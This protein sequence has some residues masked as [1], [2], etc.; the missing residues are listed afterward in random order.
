MILPGD[1]LEVLCRSAKDQV[2]L[3]APFTK[4]SALE[5][6][7]NNIANDVVIQCVTRWRP[8]E[9]VAG[10]SDLE[11]WPLLKERSDTFLWLRSDLHAKY[12]R[13][14]NQC[15]VGSA[16]ITATALGWS[17]QSNL[18]LLVPMPANDRQLAT[19]ETE[20]FI[21]CIKVDDSLFDQVSQ[22]V[23]LLTEQK[24]YVTPEQ[25]LIPDLILD[26]IGALPQVSVD[27][28]LPMLRHPEKLYIAYSGQEESL[29]TTAKI[30]A[31]SDL[32]ALS[33]PQGLPKS[34][35]EAYVGILLLQKPIIHKV[36]E[37]VITPQRFGAVRDL[38]ASLP[39]ANNSDFNASEAWQT[40]MRWLSYFLPDRYYLTVPHHSEV[41]S[42]NK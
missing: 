20:L 1:Q 25:N 13:A 33:V 16:N 19:F 22:A 9:I 5:R 37:F 18:E 42:R 36:D 10:I 8:D 29:S 31:I 3:V 40:L 23:N 24:I 2:V 35:F 39:C 38:L 15:L 41:F 6:L 30:T 34:V 21:G 32:L 7:L 12:Y 14:D 27:T 4:V 26:E 17:R 11:V 28:W